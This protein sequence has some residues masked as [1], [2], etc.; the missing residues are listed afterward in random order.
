M[1]FKPNEPRPVKFPQVNFT[2]LPPAGLEEMCG[3]LPCF[4]GRDMAISCWRVPC[5][6][7]VFTQVPISRRFARI[8]F[9]T[10]VRTLFTGKFDAEFSTDVVRDFDLDVWLT[11]LGSGHPPVSLDV[12]NPFAKPNPEKK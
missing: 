12:E 11:I 10:R 5:K 4:R 7:Y 2:Y 1:Q 3:E 9:W 8:P 6:N